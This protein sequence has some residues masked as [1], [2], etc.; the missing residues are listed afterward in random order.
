MGFFVVVVVVVGDKHGLDKEEDL[1]A[2]E[3][4]SRPIDLIVCFCFA[5]D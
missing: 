4:Q 3:I 2:A 1:W 5:F